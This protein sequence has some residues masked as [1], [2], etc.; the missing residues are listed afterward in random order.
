MYV[1]LSQFSHVSPLPSGQDQDM[2]QKK[3]NSYPP[4]HHT[5]VSSLDFLSYNIWS[6]WCHLCVSHAQTMTPLITPNQVLSAS[7]HSY[8]YQTMPHASCINVSKFP[9]YKLSHT[10]TF[11]LPNIR[12]NT[13]P[14]FK[15]TSEGNVSLYVLRWVDA[16]NWL[17]KVAVEVN[18]ASSNC[19]ISY[20][21]YKSCIT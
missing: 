12:W 9:F 1:K 5:T 3:N 17:F 16:I 13:N 20:L 14:R 8:I 6:N 19:I 21:Q 7:S 18:N 10:T 11:T 2:G 15:L 4:Y